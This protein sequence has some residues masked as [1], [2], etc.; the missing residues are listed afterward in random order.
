M[1]TFSSATFLGLLLLLTTNFAS[2]Q[3]MKPSRP[4]LKQANAAL[5]D[6]EISLAPPVSKGTHADL[7]L[8]LKELQRDANELA[9]LAQSVPGDINSISKGLLPKDL[10]DKLKR[11]EKLSKHLRSSVNP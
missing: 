2:A 4:G 10:N 5:L 11:I 3:A 1:K 6:E 8:A 9:D 7:A